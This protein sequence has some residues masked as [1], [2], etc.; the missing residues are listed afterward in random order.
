[1]YAHI[2]SCCV[3]NRVDPVAA[4]LAGVH[5]HEEAANKAM[6]AVARL[7]AGPAAAGRAVFYNQGGL[8]KLQVLMASSSKASPRVKTKAL[9]LVSDLIGELINAHPN[10]T[11]PFAACSFLRTESCMLLGI[12]VAQG[13]TESWLAQFVMLVVTL[14]SGV[15]GRSNSLMHAFWTSLA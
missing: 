13:S 12:C 3:L 14:N 1:M 11:R 2:F 4:Q 8:A 9:N 6:Y 15:Q 5:A 7:V 10:A